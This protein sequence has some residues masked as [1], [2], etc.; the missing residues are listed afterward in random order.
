MR[1]FLEYTITGVIAGAI[2]GW[3]VS[4]VSGDTLRDV[5]GIGIL[6]TLVGVVLGIVHRNDP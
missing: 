3:L 2:M 4:L 5:L 6:G 1:K